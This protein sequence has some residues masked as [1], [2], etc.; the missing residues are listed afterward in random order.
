[1][2]I[3]CQRKKLSTSITFK[4]CGLELFTPMIARTNYSIEEGGYITSGTI[5]PI[6]NKSIAMALVD[7]KHAIVDTKLHVLIRKQKVEAKVVDV[8]FV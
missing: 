3:S 7:P 6:T 5:S 8:P 1:M 2:W 4:A